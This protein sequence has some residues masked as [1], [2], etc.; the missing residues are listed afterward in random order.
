MNKFIFNESCYFGAGSI[1]EI[2][3]VM[4]N[5]HLSKP[6]V[7]T[8]NNLIEVGVFQKVTGVLIRHDI[9]YYMFSDVGEEPSVKDIKNAYNSLKKTDADFII[10]VGG[11]SVV[12]T[13]KAISLIATNNNYA[14]VVSL[15]GEKNDLNPPMPVFAV[16]TTAGSA[17]E[18]TRSFVINDDVTNSKIV[19]FNDKVVPA[20]SFVDAELMTT[21]PDIVTLSSGFDALTH[22]VECII[23]KKSNIL[24]Q[25]LAKEAI[26]II[27]KNLKLSY[28]SPEDLQARENMAY[29]SYLA[30]LAYSN[31]GL[32]LCHSIA[33]ALGGKFKI[34]HGIALAITLPAVLKFNMYGRTAKKYAILAEAFSVD[35]EKLSLEEICRQTIRAVEKFRNSFN[36]PKRLGGFGVTERN[37]DLLAY[38]SFED[39]CTGS[40]PRDVTMTDIYLLIK[41][42]I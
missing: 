8:D 6:F 14:D 15:K 37:L 40:N 21:M 39:A 28:D 32:G 18:I 7:I 1:N 5:R 25:T 26:E 33:H 4:E 20:V 12:D 30:G 13:A 34:S 38:N 41:K 2:V 22:A 23:S 31:S 27:V 3:G 42:L 16:P 29:A 17:A 19:C 9:D 36:I 35:T 24:S 10:A 11:G